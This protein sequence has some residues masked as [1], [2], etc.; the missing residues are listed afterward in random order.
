LFL[1]DV[2]T[3]ARNSS[4][5][6]R[7]PMLMH[8]LTPY[9]L[10]LIA[11]LLFISTPSWIGAKILTEKYERLAGVSRFELAIVPL[12]E[13]AKSLGL[14][15]DDLR[16]LIE[17]NLK[18]AGLPLQ[19]KSSQVVPYL[20]ADVKTVCSQES[21]V[22]G[23]VLALRFDDV[24]QLRSNTTYAQTWEW[25]LVGIAERKDVAASVLGALRDRGMP[26]FV[27]DYLKANP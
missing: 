25:N 13:E 21:P 14:S 6:R 19:K 2:G 20:L 10:F 9:R 22:C 12:S 27:L 17:A 15:R 1:S 11:S 18:R 4:K 24:V 8:G 26:N 16:F 23:F 5:A 3:F 7:V